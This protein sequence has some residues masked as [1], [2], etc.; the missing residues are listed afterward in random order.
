MLLWFPYACTSVHTHT[1][2]DT[3]A[4]RHGHFREHMHVHLYIHTCTWTLTHRDTD[5]L[6]NTKILRLIDPTKEITCKPHVVAHVCKTR[7]G[8]RI[9]S[10]RLAWLRSEFRASLS[11]ITR[12][13]LKNTWGK[14]SISFA[15][16]ALGCI[17]RSGG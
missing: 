5:T 12:L 13:C 11:Y 6:G 9:E 3:H 17:L 2:T 7:G 16:R 1:H 4:Q 14:Q 8:D 10:S 15:H